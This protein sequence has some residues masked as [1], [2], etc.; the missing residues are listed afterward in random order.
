MND[1][2]E[3][4]KKD[5]IAW[6]ECAEIYEKQ[7][8]C[9]HPDINAFENFEEDFLDRLL[10]YLIEKQDRPVKILDLGCGSGRLHIRYGAKTVDNDKAQGFPRLRDIKKTHPELAYD[11][12]LKKGLAEVWGI[13]FSLKMIE[14]AEAKIRE[15]QLD[16]VNAVPLTLKQGSAFE[17]EEERDEVLPVAVNLVNSIC[18]MQGP[19]GAVELF[20]SMRKAVE[21][22]G[23]IAIISNYQRE[24]IEH[25]GLGQYESTLDVSGHPRWMVPDIY[26]SPDYLFVPKHYIR[27]YTRDPE[28]H[29]DV[30]DKKGVL[31]KKDHVLKREPER[32]KH[33]INTGHIRTST[34]YES[35][36]YSFKEMDDWINAY[37][38]GAGETYHFQTSELDIIRAEPAQMSVLDSGSHLKHLFSR[39][40]L[41]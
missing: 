14:L 19:K 40:K 28:L 5:N 36:W 25:Y 8:V 10:L 9:G 37:W 26:A 11:P 13:D 21:K 33:V 32:T 3:K 34:D 22:A 30:Y 6:D 29:V 23:G 4:Y 27:S 31:V 17:L 12:L 16:K 1:L 18:V 39:W 15:A 20:K 38:K 35:N 24:Y 41:I 2:K 7:I